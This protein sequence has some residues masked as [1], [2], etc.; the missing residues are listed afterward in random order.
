MSKIV[1]VVAVAVLLLAGALAV[2]YAGGEAG[3]RYSVDNETWRGDPGNETNLSQSYVANASYGST[4]TVRDSNCGDGVTNGDTNCEQLRPG[5]DYVWNNE[6]GTIKA[7][8]NGSINDSEESTIS[9]RYGVPTDQQ[10]RLVGVFAT[11][12]QA[13]APLVVILMVGVALG[14]LLRFVS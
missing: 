2:G 5:E 9:Y 10:Q 12:Y 4:V 13:L 6:N 11:G 7:T 1:P 3:Q 8:E 14:A